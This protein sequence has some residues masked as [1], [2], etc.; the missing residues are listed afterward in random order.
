MTLLVLGQVVSNQGREKYRPGDFGYFGINSPH[1]E[2]VFHG[3]FT[4]RVI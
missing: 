4:E 2:G 3:F 1:L